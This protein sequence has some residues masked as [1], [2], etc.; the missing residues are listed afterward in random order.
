M[1]SIIRTALLV[2]GV[3]VLAVGLWL[4]VQWFSYHLTT[5]FY[6]INVLPGLLL[7]GSGILA[8][9]SPQRNWRFI[10]LGIFGAFVSLVFAFYANFGAAMIIGATTPVRDPARY[11]EILGDYDN[12]KL[13]THFPPHIPNDATQVT[14]YYSP[15]FLQGGSL[16]KLHCKL[17]SPQVDAVLQEY[18]PAAR[19][20]RSGTGDVL[21]SSE[22]GYVPTVLFFYEE[23]SEI[24]PVPED[25]LVLILDAEPYEPG[26]WNHGYIYG[27]AVS[28]ERQE[29]IYWT[30][31]W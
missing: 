16:L 4:D 23:D 20:I 22:P 1:Y 5:L 6:V 13:V 17:P 14:F 31:R 10:G 25:F 3:L 9:K 8:S 26:D 11:E 15:P 21:E 7:I 12:E 30:E 2:A 29:V 24:V 18:L 28:T 27:V 19:E